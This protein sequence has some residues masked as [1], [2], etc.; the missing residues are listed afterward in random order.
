MSAEVTKG[1][2]Y[3]FVAY[4]MVVCALVIAFAVDIM[5]NNVGCY[6]VLFAFLTVAMFFYLGISMRFN[7]ASPR[8]WLVVRLA[9]CYDYTPATTDGISAWCRENCRGRWNA[10]YPLIYF[11]RKSDAAL[12]KLFHTDAKIGE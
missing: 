3:V 12:F 11:S 4:F 5:H 10:S 9:Y 2:R 6:V 8:N 7:S 1:I